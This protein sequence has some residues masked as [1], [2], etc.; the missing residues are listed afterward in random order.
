[1]KAAASGASN[2]SIWAGLRLM[3]VDDHPDSAE[4]LR[5]LLE[6][7]GARAWIAIDG[8]DALVQ[9]RRKAPDLILADLRMP[10]VDGLQLVTQLRQ[11]TQW[12]DLP[13]V[14][15]TA[16]NSPADLRA[17]VEAGFDGHVAKPVDFDVL[18]ATVRRVL[19]ARRANRLGGAR[20][21]RHR[22]RRR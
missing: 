10:R 1:M 14:A 16:Y 21:G 6:A 15:V 13:V 22:P 19:E 9:L 2:P 5:E 4:G 11:W 17:T 12:V 3:I 8:I 18:T 20:G 7:K